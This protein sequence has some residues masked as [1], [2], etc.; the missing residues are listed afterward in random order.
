[1]F[2]GL[3][4]IQGDS[5]VLA[6]FRTSSLGHG[7][8]SNLFSFSISINVYTSNT[9]FDF[10]YIFDVKLKKNWEHCSSGLNT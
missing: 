1:M 8:I 5:V 3:S 4:K 6:Q 10:Y 2:Q 9:N 7:E